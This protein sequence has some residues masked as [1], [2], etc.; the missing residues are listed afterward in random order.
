LG[1]FSTTEELLFGPSLPQAINNIKGVLTEVDEQAT[2]A[3]ALVG[4]QCKD[5]GHIVVQE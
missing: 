2:V 5:A 3:L 4:G 1:R